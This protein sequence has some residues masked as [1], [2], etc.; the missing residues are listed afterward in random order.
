VIMQAERQIPRSLNQR[1]EVGNRPCWRLVTQQQEFEV[2][3]FQSLQ[4]I[5]T[6]LFPPVFS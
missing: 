5:F 6:E 1:V 3:D 4:L 2:D